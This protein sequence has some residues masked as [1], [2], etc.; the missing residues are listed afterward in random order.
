[1]NLKAILEALLFVTDKPLH[2]EK[3]KKLLSQWSL[4][5]IKQALSELKNSYQSPDSRSSRRISPSN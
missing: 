2:L 1:M 3:L 5:E 4:K